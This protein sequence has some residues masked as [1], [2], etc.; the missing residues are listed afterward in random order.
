LTEVPDRRGL[1]P[2]PCPYFLLLPPFSLWVVPTP[3]PWF[4]TEV[5]D[6]PLI[7]ELLVFYPFYFPP[8]RTT[9]NPSSGTSATEKILS[10][11]EFPE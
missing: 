3:G 6:D 8:T 10:F 7:K 4:V 5:A 9:L 1:P 11:G 2:P